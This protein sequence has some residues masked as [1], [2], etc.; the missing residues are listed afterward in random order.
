MG[1]DGGWEHGGSRKL[2]VAGR[3]RERTEKDILIEG[4]IMGLGKNLV[5]DKFTGIH[6]DK[7]C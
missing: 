1:T 7:P 5:L 3:E 2:V 6:R 4:D